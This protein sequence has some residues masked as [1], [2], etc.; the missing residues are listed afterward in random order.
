MD[1]RAL[2]NR[3]MRLDVSEPS[4]ILDCV[5]AQS[6]LLE[7][8][9]SRQF[10]DPHLLV[11]KDTVQLGG[12]KEVVI[13]DEAIMRLQGRICI[14]NV[15]GLRELIH[16]ETHSLRYS[17]HP[18]VKRMYLDLKQ[19]YWWRKIKKD[20]VSHISQCLNCQ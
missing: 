17:I 1:V 8:I 18:G 4:Q 3:F 13:E 5:V 15:N 9:K 19:H 11:L 10:D 12:V 2:A 7:R 14:P 6:S 16:E 20:V